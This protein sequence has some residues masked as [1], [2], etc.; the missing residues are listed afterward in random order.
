M[1]S[2]TEMQ[3]DTKT[4]NQTDM[5]SEVELL[6]VQMAPVMAQKPRDRHCLENEDARATLMVQALK[7]ARQTG[8]ESDPKVTS[9]ALTDWLSASNALLRKGGYIEDI[10]DEELTTYWEYA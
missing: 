7:N 8:R 9:L 6:E 2:D 3:G 4:N 10:T 1:K 5:D